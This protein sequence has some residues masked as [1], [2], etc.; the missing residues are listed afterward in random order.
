LA[1]QTEGCVVDPRTATL[2]V[3]EE[4]R[5]IWAFSARANGAT[6]GRLVAAVDNA[7]LAADVEGLTLMPAG[8]QGGWLI[9]S[10]QGDNAYALFSLPD[11]KPAGRFRIAAG[12]LAPPRK[13][14][15]SPWPP[16]PS[17]RPIR[18][19]CHRPGWG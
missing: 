19:G 16:V 4:D 17:A 12:A 2:Y 13:P 3:G 1:T 14:T 9:A 5:G 6:E 15:A 10:S 11:L 7:Q 8:E 18:E